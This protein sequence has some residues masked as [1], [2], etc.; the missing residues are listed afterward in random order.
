MVTNLARVTD[1]VIQTISSD[2]V[3][4]SVV[5]FMI[6]DIKN[7]KG[8]GC[9]AIGGCDWGWNWGSDNGGPLGSARLLCLVA[10]ASFYPWRL[11]FYL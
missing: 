1:G 7:C 3:E 2:R 5:L 6:V 4:S 10:R 11:C 9:F 8:Y